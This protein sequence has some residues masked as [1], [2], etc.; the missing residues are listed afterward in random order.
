MPTKTYNQIAGRSLDR[1]NAL[2]DG[3]FAFAMT[4]IVLDIRIPPHAAIHSEADLCAAIVALIL[5]CGG[6]AYG[7][8]GEATDDDAVFLVAHPAFRDAGYFHRYAVG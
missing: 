2:S 7:Q 3:L 8:D 5:C 4:V 1:L 6:A